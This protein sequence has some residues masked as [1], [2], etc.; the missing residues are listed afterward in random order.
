MA[1]DRVAEA[2]AN[3]PVESWTV[4]HGVRVPGRRQVID[5]VLVGPPGVHVVVSEK[6]QGQVRERDVREAA[7]AADAVASYLTSVIRDDVRPVLCHDTEDYVDGWSDGVVVAS[8]GTVVELVSARRSVLGPDEVRAVA[9]ELAG[10]ATPTEIAKR[11]VGSH[12][13]EPERRR[14]SLRLVRRS[15]ALPL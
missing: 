8:A 11:P 13:A 5:H 2:L 7:D 1:V 9:M 4:L 10:L 15:A 3:L 12:R 6:W 14:S